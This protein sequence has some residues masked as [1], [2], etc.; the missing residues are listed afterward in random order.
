M[1]E[2]FYGLSVG[3]REQLAVL[4]RLAF[5]E[6]LAERG[7]PARVILDDA[8]VNTDEPRFDRMLLI[9]RRAA[10]NIQI[11]ALTCRERDYQALGA[12]FIRLN[13]CASR[14]PI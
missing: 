5:A 4:T 10:R 1:E 8:L 13:E 11:I 6:M 7:K 9:L 12:P 3:A 2:P 14:T